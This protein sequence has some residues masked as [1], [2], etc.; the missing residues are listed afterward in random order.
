MNLA[1]QELFLI[2][3]SIFRKYD[4]YDGNDKQ[5]GPTLELVDTVRSRDVDMNADMIIPYPARGSH[6]VKIRVRN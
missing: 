2:L 6:G 3:S 1:R 4:L 5:A